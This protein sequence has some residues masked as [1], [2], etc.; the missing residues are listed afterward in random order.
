MAKACELRW[1][2]LLHSEAGKSPD[3]SLQRLTFSSPWQQEI[4]P[5]PEALATATQWAINLE[6]CVILCIRVTVNLLRMGQFKWDFLYSTQRRSRE[7]FFMRVHHYKNRG[8]FLPIPNLQP[9]TQKVIVHESGD[10]PKPFTSKGKHLQRYCLL[11]QESSWSQ[12]CWYTP[13]IP[14]SW[15]RGNRLAIGSRPA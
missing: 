13:V 5:I 7:L 1:S 4:V 9:I 14:R 3:Q 6:P 8:I 10:I 15:S 12:I 2:V 11:H